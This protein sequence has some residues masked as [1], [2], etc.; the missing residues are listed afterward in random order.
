ML[1]KYF[2]ILSVK[3]QLFLDSS[4]RFKTL[5]GG[6]L[7]F[8][9]GIT[10]LASTIYF[11]V[12]LFGRDT[13]TVMMSESRNHFPFKNWTNEQI[14]VILVDR[15]M[16][17][18]PN[19]ERIFDYYADSWWN[20]D[21]L[22][23]KTGKIEW[24]NE[25]KQVYLEKCN[26]EEHFPGEED[27]WR[28]QKLINSS[29]CI[30]RNQNLPIQHTFGDLNFTS[31]VFWIHRCRNTT[32][33]NDC[34][35]KEKIEK[36]LENV[37]L[38]VRFKDYTLDH[39][40]IKEPKVPYIYSDMVQASSTTY[41]RTW[42]YFA[43]VEY[44]S[45]E[46]YVFEHKNKQSLNIFSG[47]R[48]ATDLRTSA[49]VPGTFA[50]ASFYNSPLKKLYNRRYYKAQ[51]MIADLGGIIKG[52]LTIGYVLNFLVS[53]YLY[54]CELLNFNSDNFSMNS[55]FDGREKEIKESKDLNN[56]LEN[57][58]TVRLKVNNY[59]TSDHD[60]NKSKLASEEDLKAKDKEAISKCNHLK[61]KRMLITSE[62]GIN[63]NKNSNENLVQDK[64]LK[65]NCLKKFTFFQKYSPF[66]VDK[67]NKQNVNKLLDT[68]KKQLDIREVSDIMFELQKI[69]Y[70]LFGDVKTLK[71]LKV[72]QIYNSNTKENKAV[73]EK[74]FI[75]SI[76]LNYLSL[77]RSP[78][79]S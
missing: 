55:L 34:Y 11:S 24:K 64:V 5:F 43:N 7:S 20:R 53:E 38:Q 13:Y 36:E 9:C 19:W 31:I 14:S 32:T 71:S 44:E 35:P 79:K 41:K 29:M 70:V 51:N 54:D 57:S 60:F 76:Y 40:V 27:L 37:F 16:N 10:L 72:P 63:N 56:S 6:I 8:L 52:I 67:V 47:T 15:F 74:V 30:K 26:L 1:F 65:D 12:L 69:S 25:I 68:I 17:E 50:V 28:D 75:K 49:T 22:D 66:C 2:D 3:P 78:V 58:Q 61:P 73:D 42:Y 48:D 4:S 62:I 23:N 59:L 33:K 18:V 21:H 46:G 77:K 39:S 45:D